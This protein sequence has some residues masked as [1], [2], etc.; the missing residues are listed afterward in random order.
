[1]FDADSF[2]DFPNIFSELEKGFREYSVSFFKRDS[3]ECWQY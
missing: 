3:A 1:M 2:L